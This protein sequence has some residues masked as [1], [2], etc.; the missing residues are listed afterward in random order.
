[1]GT[2]V[3]SGRGVG[4]GSGVAEGTTVAVVG[5]GDGDGDAVSPLPQAA[6]TSRAK[7]RTDSLFVIHCL[8]LYFSTPVMTTPCIKKRCAMRKRINGTITATK[9]AAW[10][11]FD[12]WE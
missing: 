8:S 9:D 10:I 11:K 5:E 6:H 3:G 12:D 4:S 1:M 2:E 7:T